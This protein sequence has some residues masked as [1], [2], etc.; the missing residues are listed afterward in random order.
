MV[1]HLN[2]PCLLMTAYVMLTRSV[3][4]CGHSQDRG[5]RWKTES[6]RRAASKAAIKNSS[7][8]CKRQ[9]TISERKS[10]AEPGES[11]PFSVEGLR[12]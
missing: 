9:G 4:F 2:K 11:K 12:G 6:I 7:G 10:P 5:T 1:L 8:I 3:A